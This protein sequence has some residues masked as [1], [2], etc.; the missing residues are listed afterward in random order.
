MVSTVGIDLEGAASLGGDLVLDDVAADEV[1]GQVAAGAGGA[2]A[3]DVD[4]GA[5]LLPYLEEALADGL[6]G[7]ARGHEITLGEDAAVAVDD[8]EVGRD[9]ADVDAQ[10]G[11]D[12]LARSGLRMEDLGRQNGRLVEAEGRKLARGA[13]SR[14]GREVVEARP[15][16]RD[17]FSG[18][19]RVQSGPDGAHGG[20]VLGDDEVGLVET[21]DVAHGLHD[22]RVGRHAAL[23]GDRGLDRRRGADS[24][25]EVARE[26][27]A[28]AGDDVVDRR[29]LLLEVDHVRLGED[30]AAA[31]HS[32]RVLAAKGEAA[33]VL[34]GEAEAVSLLVEERARTGGAHRVHREVG[35]LGVAGSVVAEEEELGVLAADL[36]NGAD[37][38][39]QKTGRCGLGDDLIDEVAAK[40]TS[41]NAATGTRG[42]KAHDGVAEAGMDIAQ[43]LGRRPH[44]LAV[45]AQ[46]L[47]LNHVA[48]VVEQ[49]NIHAYG[50]DVHADNKRTTAHLLHLLESAR[51]RV[52]IIE[53]CYRCGK[54]QVTR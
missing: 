44:G 26:G 49:R 23:E 25:L 54:L 31:R 29:R 41:D 32:R 3:A 33:E 10:V 35:D 39:V 28:E 6:D 47:L 52:A 5:D 27:V 16:G 37:L 2:D 19:L 12:A 38:G 53:P 7:P 48:A 50:T 8:D 13:L 42:G 18:G 34:D 43:G 30:R 36:E 9:G 40:E 24:A 20:E 22:A 46:V 14:E 17:Q 51:A 1:A 21:E 15:V 4:E 11:R 45:V